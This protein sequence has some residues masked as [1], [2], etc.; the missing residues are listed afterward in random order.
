L[1][2]LLDNFFPVLYWIEPAK[3]KA[4]CW[5]FMDLDGDIPLSSIRIGTSSSE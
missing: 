2:K 3:R 4:R 5:Y 1:E